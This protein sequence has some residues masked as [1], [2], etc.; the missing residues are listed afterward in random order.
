MEKNRKRIVILISVLAGTI[1][2]PGCRLAKREESIRPKKTFYGIYVGIGKNKNC[3]GKIEGKKDKN[4]LIHFKKLNGYFLYMK[5]SSKKNMTQMDSDPQIRHLH[6]KENIQSG[7]NQKAKTKEWK[8]S[9][10]INVQET[11]NTVEE[12]LY[13]VYK[14]QD[15]T[16]YADLNEMQISRV[17][18]LPKGASVALSRSGT[19]GKHKITYSMTVQ[20]SRAVKKIQIIEMD[21][22]DRKIK[23]T[24][25]FSPDQKSYQMQKKTSYVIINEKLAGTGSKTIM[26]RK[27]YSAKK[28]LEYEW[29]KL[30]KDG[31]L[32]PVKLKLKK[33]RSGV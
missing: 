24:A 32:T 10:T 15:G 25:Y 3:N 5:Y 13:P 18:G 9:G 14:R 7:D 21:A 29:Q 30:G 16:F 12:R 1:L 19:K 22:K 20:S 28:S 6:L 4:G 26:R 31:V 8:V 11:E 2:L 23:K 27:I 17:E 33:E